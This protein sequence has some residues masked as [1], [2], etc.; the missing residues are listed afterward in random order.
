MFPMMKRGLNRCCFRKQKNHVD[1][2]TMKYPDMEACTDAF[3]QQEIDAFVSADNIVSG[4][5]GITPV[6]MIGKVPYYLCVTKDGKN[7][8]K[9]MPTD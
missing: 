2:E 7:I 3:D 9:I 1:I 4:Y 5:S 6:D 8:M